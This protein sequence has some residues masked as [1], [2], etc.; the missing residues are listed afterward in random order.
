MKKALAEAK[1]RWKA[2]TP[3]FWKKVIKAMTSLSVICG[4]VLGLTQIPGFEVDPIFV[5]VV[6]YVLAACVA[7]GV[8]AKFTKV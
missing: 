5:K 7:C 2:A 3:V 6:S 8:Q 4:S 1:S